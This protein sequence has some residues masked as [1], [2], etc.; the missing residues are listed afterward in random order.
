MNLSQVNIAN[1]TLIITAAE[2]AQTYLGGA[3]QN[4]PA[5][6]PLIGGTMFWNKMQLLYGTVEVQGKLCGVGSHT[7]FWLFDSATRQSLYQS[8]PTA[9][10]YIAQEIDIAEGKPNQYGN[11]TTLHQGV[12][13]APGTS[14]DTEVTDYHLNTHTYRIE[15]TPSALTFFIDGVQTATGSSPTRPMI[16]VIDIEQ[17]DS[18]SGATDPANFPNFLEVDY[19][20]AWDQYGNLVFSDDFDGSP[21]FQ[22]L[23]MSNLVFAQDTLGS[24]TG[25]TLATAYGQ[26]TT[27]KSWLL[28]MAAVNTTSAVTISLTDTLGNTWQQVGSSFLA[29]AWTLAIFQVEQNAA[30]GG[31]NTVTL[32]SSVSDALRLTLVEYTGQASGNP[33]DSFISNSYFTAQMSA[34]PFNPTNTNETEVV[35]G[36][37]NSSSAVTSADGSLRQSGSSQFAVLED[38][39]FPNSS[40]YQPNW[41]NG[42]L[43]GVGVTF[44]VKT[45]AGFLS[46]LQA[47]TA[48]GSVSTSESL[49]YSSSTTTGSLLICM[50]LVTTLSTTLSVTDT[51]GNTWI[52]VGSLTGVG[53]N[54]QLF[55]C[56]SNAGG[57]NTVT[58]HS[59]TSAQLAMVIGEYSGQSANPI[60]VFDY[61]TWAATAPDFTSISL[62]ARTS[63][64]ITMGWLNNQSAVS[65]AD[66]FV[67]LTGLNNGFLEDAPRY[68]A[69][70][71][72]A[73]NG[74]AVMALAVKST[75]S[76]PVGTKRGTRSK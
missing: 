49:A 4:G 45:S 19:V 32:T 6:L 74:G 9:L 63:I 38:R 58:L 73:S 15:W 10:S 23:N 34:G 22:E 36:Q 16:F 20:K 76:A 52:P 57:A 31:P 56:V 2:N 26:N 59:T 68:T 29:G 46:F 64:P 41:V 37:L 40:S 17:T 7:T 75:S 33:I 5:S 8:D 1:S 30:G 69:F 51:L 13:N 21:A 12:V 55:V 39:P 28:A 18:S 70:W 54:I 62:S 67:R 66:G 27:S 50:G 25:T 24:G 3:N 47:R 14:A 53:N 71:T 35:I 61:A 65:G 11:T 44:E 72:N 43:G 60:G 42:S 48:I